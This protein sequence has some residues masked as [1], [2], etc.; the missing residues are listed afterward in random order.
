M[1]PWDEHEL[2]RFLDRSLS[3]Y[4]NVPPREGLEGR[5]ITG[6]ASRRP[7][8]THPWIWTLLP[9]AAAV[10][11][12]VLWW[13]PKK[14][15]PAPPAAYVVLP[16]VPAVEK[17]S[18]PRVIAAKQWKPQIQQNQVAETVKNEPRLPTFPSQPDQSQARMLLQFVQGSPQTAQQVVQEEEEF[19]RL[20][21]ENLGDATNSDQELETR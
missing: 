11:M 17:R 13:M 4:S 16:K 8:R 3:E 9:T 18:T 20:V 6:L 19:R 12:A 10:V 21:A 15:V 1:K 5:I 2:E 7:E 14:E